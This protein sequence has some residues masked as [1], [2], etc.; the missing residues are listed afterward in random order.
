MSC[1]SNQNVSVTIKARARRMFCRISVR[2]MINRRRVHTLWSVSIP[3]FKF[4]WTPLLRRSILVY[5]DISSQLV[6]GKKAASSRKHL[7]KVQTESPWF[8]GFG[9][10]SKASQAWLWYQAL[11]VWYHKERD[12]SINLLESLFLFYHPF[13]K[14]HLFI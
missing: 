13:S 4:T 12:L 14:I 10:H 7:K 8:G 11:S 6:T 9:F 2:S 1:K 3:W 5:Q